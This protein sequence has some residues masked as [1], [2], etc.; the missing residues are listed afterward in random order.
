MPL[1]ARGE[2]LDVL[3]RVNLNMAPIKDT[4]GN[5]INPDAL[6]QVSIIQPSG[7][8]LLGLTS[9]GVTQNGVGQF[10][11][12]FTVPYNGPYG[13]YNDLWVFFVN[14]IRLEFQN[15]F[16]VVKTD[17][18]SIQSDGYAH[19]G[20]TTPYTYSQA[21]IKNINKLLKMLKARLNSAGKSQT[22]DAFGN[23]IFVDCDIFSI[24]TLVAFLAISL[25]DFNEVPYWTYFQFD[26]DDFIAQFGN[27][28]VEGATLN[29]L[30]SRALIEKGAEHTITDNGISFNPPS[31]ADLMMS[32]YS[33]LL[34]HYWERLRMIKNNMRPYIRGLGT[35]SMTNGGL[36]PAINR[37]RH[38]RERRIL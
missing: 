15:A 1:K 11:Y 28:L 22:T 12:V 21:A 6:P 29:A 20:A 27:V 10:S 8:V 31:V 33:T 37:L 2:T 35:F 38:L 36:N 16:V 7:N 14:G 4:Q 34:T 18:P 17:V 26:D 5:A 25:S 30:T 23:K 32:Q 19:L 13:V 24:D 3:D 9:A